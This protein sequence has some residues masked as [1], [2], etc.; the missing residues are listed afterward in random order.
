MI[1]WGIKGCGNVTEVKSGPAFNKVKN[2]VLGA[3]STGNK[4]QEPR[5]HDRVTLLK[6]NRIYNYDFNYY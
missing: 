1:N 5:T 3:G 2:Q 4:N 6:S